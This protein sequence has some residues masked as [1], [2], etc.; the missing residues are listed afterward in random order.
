M[1]LR[2]LGDGQYEVTEQSVEEMNELDDRVVAAI[3]A[4]DGSAFERA[5]REL[6]G[7]V[8][9]GARRLPDDHLG[10]SDLVLPGPDATLEE[11]R[12]MLGAEGLIPG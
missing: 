4:G 7:R 3:E 8:R 12:S 1:I 11:V 6:L 9:S 5:L 10:P 2:V